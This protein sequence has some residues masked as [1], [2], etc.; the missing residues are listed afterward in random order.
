MWAGGASRAQ[1]D[2]D[3]RRSCGRVRR[4]RPWTGA[5]KCNRLGCIPAG[6]AVFRL[7]S[8]EPNG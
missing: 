8:E 2:T 3:R 4:A 7:A 5:A 1:R 6:S